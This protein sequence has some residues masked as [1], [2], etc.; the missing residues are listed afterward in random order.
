[1][2]WVVRRVDWRSEGGFGEV[3]VGWGG[4]DGG[5]KGVEERGRVGR[6]KSELIAYELHP[7]R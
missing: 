4:G 5:G 1:M 7:G 2:V 3:V 6:G